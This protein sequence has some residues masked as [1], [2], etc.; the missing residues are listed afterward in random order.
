[1]NI[2]FLVW[3]TGCLMVPRLGTEKGK[4][5]RMGEGKNDAGLHGAMGRGD[6]EYQGGPEVESLLVI[7][8]V[9]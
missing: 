7:R 9:R 8:K 2:G 1:M 4:Q 3:V 6:A 5:A